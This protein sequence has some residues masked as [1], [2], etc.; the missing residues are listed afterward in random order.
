MKNIITPILILTTMILFSSGCKNKTEDTIAPTSDY[1]LILKYHFDSTQVRLNNFGQPEAIAAG[2]GAQSPHFNLMSSHYIEL[3]KDSLTLLGGGTVLYRAPETM[4]GGSLAID[5]SK[6]IG[7]GEGQNFY[8]MPLKNITAGTYQWLRISL[9]YQNYNI[10]FRTSGYNL[11]GTLASF[12][13]FNTYITSF[14]PRSQM[15]ALNSNRLQGYWAFEIDTMGINQVY[16]G[17][18]PGTTVPNPLNATSPIPTGSCVVTGSFDQPLVITG[19]ETKDIVINVSLSVN[20]SFEW[21]DAAGDNIF[22][23]PMDTVV[24]MGIRGVIPYVIY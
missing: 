4:L 6:S 14:S 13:G 11:T 16:Q 24:D 8:S 17:Q 22:E 9:A 5:F 15:V 19:N 2:H 12:I 3:A 21:K 10:N 18:A 23:I 1:K 7:A 20:N